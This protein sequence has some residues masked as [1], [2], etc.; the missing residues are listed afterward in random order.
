MICAR[1][2]RACFAQIT[3]ETTVAHSN[4]GDDATKLEVALDSPLLSEHLHKGWNRLELLLVET[5]LWITVNGSQ[6]AEPIELPTGGF[7]A[8]GGIA[9]Q[10]ALTI[11]GAGE[12]ALASLF[13]R[14]V[15]GKR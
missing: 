8:P 2:K 12:V 3:V 5:T 6:I 7:L 9:L 14:A 11:E 4:Q 1:K 15:D 13:V 10:G